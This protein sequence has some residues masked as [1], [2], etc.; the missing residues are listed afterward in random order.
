LGLLDKFKNKNKDK[1]E[2]STADYLY[3]GFMITSFF[4]DGQ[5]TEEQAMKIP[6]VAAAVDLITSS[7]AQLPIYL[8]KQTEN[9]VVE[10]VDDKRV[11]LLNEEPNELTNGYNFKKQIVKDYLFYGASYTKIEKF[12]NDVLGLYRL[13]IKE[14]TVTK[15]KNGYKFSGEVNFYTE[16]FLPEEL[17]IIL[18]D[19]ED[20]ITSTGILYNHGDLLKLALDEM[21][22]TSSIMKNGALP[23]GILKSASRLTESA[24]N[25]LRMAWESLYTGPK[26]A[27]KTIILE[28]GLSY[29]PVSIKP[30]ELELTNLKKN[31]VS[32]IA[33]IF[34]VPESMINSDANKYASN[35][36]NNL[37][38]L[39]YC[40]SP[41]LSS[42][43]S[44]LN[45]SLLLE[46]EK[47][48]GY[49]FRFDTS[50]LLRTTEKEKVDSTVA[51]IKGGI[52]S[53]NEGR[54][55]FDLPRLDVDYFM[56]G[57]GSVFYNPATGVMTIPN[58]GIVIDPKNAQANPQSNTPINDQTNGQTSPQTNLQQNPQ[59]I[60]QAPQNN[61]LT[62]N[63][64][65]ENQPQSVNETDQQLNV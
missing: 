48:N 46:D 35:E 65:N 18:K 61:D 1:E 45:K 6:S 37:Y 3:G 33:R 11:F 21:D 17:I 47:K 16:T 25:R 32:E 55:R 27:G 54:S 8:Y 13:P 51:A 50:E 7:V 9:G 5:V 12:R 38:F 20:G 39:Q 36:Q 29:E 49:Y 30:N 40:I 22:Y 42:I 59:Q 34:N 28:E 44:A 15:Y 43:E 24:I 60:G 64:T 58:M 10:K 53:I 62:Q 57:L 14:I 52:M 26:R 31:I 63:I 23:I 2:R 19:S 56:W 41:I 4:G